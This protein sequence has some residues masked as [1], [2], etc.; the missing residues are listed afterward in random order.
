MT[1]LPNYSDVV[2]SPRRLAETEIRHRCHDDR[3]KPAVCGRSKPTRSQGDVDFTLSRDD[4]DD[5]FR[6]MTNYSDTRPC[7]MDGSIDNLFGRNPSPQAVAYDPVYRLRP[8]TS[9]SS[10]R[11]CRV[12]LGLRIV[13]C[14]HRNRQQVLVHETCRKCAG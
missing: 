6:S 13:K 7:R 5:R 14:E 1:S 4:I 2:V 8:V 3:N 10:T 12:K 11:G 9:R